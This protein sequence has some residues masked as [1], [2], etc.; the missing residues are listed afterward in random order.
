MS[1]YRQNGAVLITSLVLL[2]LLTIL[3]LASIQNT[4]LEEKMAGNLRSGAVALQAA[5]AALRAGENRINGWLLRPAPDATGSKNVWILDSPDPIP[6]TSLAWWQEA[7]A[8]WWQ[9]K[10]LAYVGT[11][12]FASSGNVQAPRY[13]LEE[14]GL[15][16]DNLN[17]GQ[18]QDMSGRQFYQ[19]TARGTGVSQNSVSLLRSTYARRY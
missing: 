10:G 3:G 4:S 16:K 19:V 7:D 15:I 11:L 13:L 8:A 9:S 5:E 17:V 6:T 1:G 18:S 14:I 2:V 12:P